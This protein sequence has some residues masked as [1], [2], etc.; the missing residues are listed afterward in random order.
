MRAG[1]ST[2][3]VRALFTFLETEGGPRR[4]GGGGGDASGVAPWQALLDATRP[5]LS[6]QRLALV[7]LAFAKMD[8]DGKGHVSPEAVTQR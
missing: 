8:K 3:E 6:G 1:L 7:R 2:P 4:A 5:R